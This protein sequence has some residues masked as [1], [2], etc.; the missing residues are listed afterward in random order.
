MR[1]DPIVVVGAARTPVGAFQGR[2]KNISA[3]EL[4]ST[5]INAVI[6][7][8]GIAPDRVDEVVMGCVLSAGQGQAPARQAALGAGLPL[9]VMCT[10]VNKMCGSGMK[11]T[12][13]AHD[14]IAAG[15]SKVLIAGGQESMTNAPYLLPKVRD[16]HR[17]GHGMVIDHMFLDGL[18]DAYEQGKLMGEFAEQCATQ[19]SR[20]PEQR[21]Q[22]KMALSKER[23]RL[24]LSNPEKEKLLS[25]WMRH[26]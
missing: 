24:W 17:L 3:T 10:T 4:G 22:L 7:R 5:A 12:M 19:L 15:S 9:G 8:A 1:N 13:L 14:M 23:L 25:I 6:E 18:E 11:S 2:L 20:L 26:H 16:G 21:K